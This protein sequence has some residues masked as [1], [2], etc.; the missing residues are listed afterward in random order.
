MLSE[1]VAEY[2]GQ[3]A[4]SVPNSKLILILFRI[5]QGIGCYPMVLWQLACYLVQKWPEMISR[6]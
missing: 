1:S 3:E 6:K 2:R 4:F 5:R